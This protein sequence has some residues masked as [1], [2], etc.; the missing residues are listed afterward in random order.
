M[1]V[2][3]VL[4]LLILN[5]GGTAQDFCATEY[6]PKAVQPSQVGF[7]RT[8]YEWKTIPVVVH[9]IYSDSLGGWF[10]EQYVEEA[11]EDLDADMEEA[12]I[13]IELIHIGYQDLEEYAW[14]ENYVTGQ[15][16]GNNEWCFPNF[17]T[18]NTLMAIDQWFPDY[19]PDYYC[20]IYVMPKICGGILGWSYV[21]VTGT[22]A[23][24]GIWLRSDIFGLDSP[25]P[26][27]NENKVL[28]HE[29]GHYC[30]LH[31]TFMSVANCGD[32]DGLPCDVWGDFVCD[33]PPT[34]AQWECDPPMC[35]EYIYDYTADNHMD[36]YPDSCRQHFTPGQID[37][38]HTM[39]EFQRGGL[40]GDDVFCFGDVNLD[41][42]VGSADLLAA[43]TCF[44]IP[45]CLT[46]D[47][48]H[49][50][51]VTFLDIAMLLSRYGDYCPGY[52]P[53]NLYREGSQTKKGA[54]APFRLR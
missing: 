6:D 22:N 36:Y 31:H 38:M 11:I 42:I 10:S 28:T 54:E 35:P 44:G 13:D 3:I 27:N 47:L 46:G 52:E 15:S 1:K 32:D 14:Y 49:N 2:L 34:K 9:I 26:R 33:T 48:D 50:G 23:R 45:G 21:T 4:L 7:Q 8:T 12:M 37:R 16:S 20:N 25:H 40:F 43:L 30:G 19:D 5:I 51:I 39:L 53:D 17:G 41:H 18:Q 29:M 24:D